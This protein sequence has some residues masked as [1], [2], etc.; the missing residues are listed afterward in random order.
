MRNRLDV[1]SD[2]ATQ[3]STLLEVLL[4]LEDLD[5]R[6]LEDRAWTAAMLLAGIGKQTAD[7][8]ISLNDLNGQITGR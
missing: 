3:A 2:A 8:K 6:D 1:A 5:D 7:F 4:P